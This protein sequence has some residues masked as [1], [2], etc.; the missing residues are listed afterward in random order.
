MLVVHKK[1]KIFNI[2]QQYYIID[3]K[4]S[5]YISAINSENKDDIGSYISKYN[6]S[7]IMFVIEK[8]IEIIKNKRQ[9]YYRIFNG[10]YAFWA[11]SEQFN[12]L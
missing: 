9:E 10:E 11:E 6:M 1:Y 4:L 8:R 2:I 7:N 3:D 5:D 12:I